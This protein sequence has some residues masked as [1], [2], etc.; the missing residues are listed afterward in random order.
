MKRRTVV[1]DDL[2]VRLVEGPGPGAATNRLGTLEDR[3][4]ESCLCESDRRRESVRTCADDDR[5]RHDYVTRKMTVRCTT[6][7]MTV[8]VPCAITYAMRLLRNVCS[9]TWASQV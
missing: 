9:Q 5:G 4:V 2:G 1:D 8:A 7:L 6:K 3:H